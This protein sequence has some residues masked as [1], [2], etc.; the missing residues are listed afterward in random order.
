MRRHI[1][2]AASLAALA[3]SCGCVDE[4]PPLQTASAETVIC[5]NGATIDGIDVS[6]WQGTIDWNAVAGDGIEFAFIRVSDGLTYYDTEFQ[7]NWANARAAGIV[8]GAYQYFRPG[9]DAVAQAQLLLSEMGSLQAGDLPPVIDVETTDGYSATQVADAVSDWIYT[10]ETETGRMPI[11]YTGSY[12]WESSV[13]TADFEDYPLWVA[14]W[15]ASCPDTPDYW[16]HWE[17]WQTSCTGWVNGISGNVDTNLFNG[18]LATLLAFAEGTVECGDG[19]CNGDETPETCPEDCPACEPIPSD[20]GTVDET[21]ECFTAGGNPQWWRYEDD[22][23]ADSLMWTHTTDSP[24]VDNYGI[25]ALEFEETGLYRLEAYT[26]APWAQSQQARY[27]IVHGPHIAEAV[28][29]Q[30]ETDGWNALGEFEFESGHA[31]SVRLDD[32]TGEPYD[33]LTQ[34]VYDA[35]RLTRLDD[36]G[37]DDDTAMPDDD[38]GDDD[39]SM[40]DDDTSMTDDDVGP[41]HSPPDQEDDG[42]CSCDAAEPRARWLPSALL[43]SLLLL[44]LR[45]G[46]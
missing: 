36:P 20:G 6:Y 12:F 9:E 8:R 33:A 28:I 4:R 31:Q 14:N 39:T 38:T 35:I 29:D 46:R 24:D 19:I 10:V 15:H 27:E 45:R 16:N 23:W 22:G 5:P 44:R 11:I 41:S 25:W 17:F 2:L 18:D 1:G 42:G 34:I 32:N 13:A 37:D 3:V 21:G 26:A 40:T 30:G 7:T 43:T